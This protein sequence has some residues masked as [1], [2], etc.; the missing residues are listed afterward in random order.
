MSVCDGAGRGVMVGLHPRLARWAHIQGKEE[1]GETDGAGRGATAGLH[2][3]L[4][5]WAHIQDKKG[6]EGT[7]SS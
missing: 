4:A 6:K 5:H 1:G 7:G 2:P 3:R